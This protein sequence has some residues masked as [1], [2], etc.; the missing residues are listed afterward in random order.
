MSV[1][2][3]KTFYGSFSHSNKLYRNNT[4]Q[5]KLCPCDFLGEK[6]SKAQLLPCIQFELYFKITK[7]LAICWPEL[8]TVSNQLFAYLLPVVVTLFKYKLNFPSIVRYFLF[9]RV[10][11]NKRTISLKVSRENHQEVICSSI[12]VIHIC[13]S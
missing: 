1:I 13:V 7:D 5:A 10:L 9:Y 2:K 3:N 8:T 11:K 4:N 6:Y 12:R